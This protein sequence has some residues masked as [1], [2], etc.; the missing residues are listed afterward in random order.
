M[1]DKY[2]REFFN[3]DT[4]TLIEEAEESLPQTPEEIFKET[5]GE[6]T[7][8]K[9]RKYRWIVSEYYDHDYQEWTNV[10][11][12]LET[13]IKD[14]FPNAGT[15]EHFWRALLEK[16]VQME[17]LHLISDVPDIKLNDF[18][19]CL[20]DSLRQD[21]PFLDTF[22]D[23]FS[24][25]PVT[26]SKEVQE[27]FSVNWITKRW[28]SYSTPDLPEHIQ[29]EFLPNIPWTFFSG[30]EQRQLID[31]WL[32]TIE[33]RF[34]LLKNI[35]FF[36]SS[37]IQIIDLPKVILMVYTDLCSDSPLFEEFKQLKERLETVF[38]ISQTT[39]M[40]AGVP[41]EQIRALYEKMLRASGEIEY[42][43]EFEPYIGSKP[44]EVGMSE[45]TI[46]DAV[47]YS[48]QTS[49][50][51]TTSKIHCLLTLLT[52]TPEKKRILLVLDGIGRVSKYRR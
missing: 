24:L 43:A 40:G 15:D 28:K 14:V 42:L 27:T 2:R 30:E 33:G 23:A 48:L 25:N 11:A 39:V 26:L 1:K 34:A 46:F 17:F 7:V 41:S 22:T 20:P 21:E 6:K 35:P 38:N 4:G 12:T 32:Q 5:F 50:L 49:G 37:L 47:D 10:Y 3:Q 18:Y 36:P 9:M 51:E 52:E 44:S 8:M 29:S 13:F 31:S 16:E 45:D 19:A